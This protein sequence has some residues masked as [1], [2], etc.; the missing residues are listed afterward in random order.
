[1]GRVLRGV[2]GLYD[3]QTGG[4]RI[5]RCRPR[6]KIKQSVTILAGDR[7]R[8]LPLGENEGIIEEV[9]PRST[10]IY[11][12]AVANV[13]QLIVV[14]ACARPDPQL[15][16]MDKLL[17]LAESRGLTPVVCL[18]KIDLVPDSVP[19]ELAAIY[20]KAGYTVLKCSAKLGVGIEE[21]RRCLQGKTSSFAGPSGA[22]KSSLLNAVQPGL[23][24]ITGEVSRKTGRGRQTTRQVALLPL[25]CG[26]YVADTPGFSQLRLDD[27]DQ[28]KLDSYFPELR[29]YKTYCRFTSCLHRSEPD[30][31]VKE[32]LKDGQIAESRYQ[33]YVL[34][35]DELED[36]ARTR[37]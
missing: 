9:L 37:Y 4:G 27:L 26:G 16:L 36:L 34:L 5:I 19:E 25:E 14:S 32:A 24:L 18:N 13:D 28:L 1:M 33:N 6:G 21:L 12:P 30:C 11:R 35:L 3:V 31:G 22:G 20:E 17:V 2:G 29:K 8:Y 23:R 7:V 10:V 15:L